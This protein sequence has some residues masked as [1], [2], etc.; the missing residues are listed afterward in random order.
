MVGT[1]L[2]SIQGESA[3]AT[4]SG[5]QLIAYN[6]RNDSLIS[7]AI[8]ESGNS[9]SGSQGL[10]YYQPRVGPFTSCAF[11]TPANY[12]TVQR[13]RQHDRMCQCR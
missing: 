3:G 5:W 6:G 10:D 12:I 7:G 9:I 2:M 4:D 13:P 1:I 11:E 8:M